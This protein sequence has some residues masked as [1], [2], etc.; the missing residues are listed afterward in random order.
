[1]QLLVNTAELERRT[2]VAVRDT[3]LSKGHL[4]SAL[5]LSQAESA[6]QTIKNS[7]GRRVSENTEAWGE[8]DPNSPKENTTPSPKVLGVIFYLPSHTNLMLSVV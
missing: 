1:M 8:K 5:G 6:G 2:Q 3:A 4:V 7:W